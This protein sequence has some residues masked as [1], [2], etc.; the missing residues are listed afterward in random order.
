MKLRKVRVKNKTYQHVYDKV[1]INMFDHLSN[2]LSG[3]LI[4]G[5]FE[6]THNQLKRNVHDQILFQIKLNLSL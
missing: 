4:M 6:K 5:V 1:R 2:K 3:D